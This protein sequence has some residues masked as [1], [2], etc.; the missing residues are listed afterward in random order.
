MKTKREFNELLVKVFD[1]NKF[2]DVSINNEIDWCY[3]IMRLD[4]MSKTGL[5]KIPIF[6]MKMKSTETPQMF[7][8]R[9]RD[10]IELYTKWFFQLSELYD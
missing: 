4:I 10:K 6:N 8:Y 1:K 2:K 3:G 5:L 7:S 9:L